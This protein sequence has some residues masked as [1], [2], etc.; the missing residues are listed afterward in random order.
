M[1]VLNATIGIMFPSLWLQVSD[2]ITLPLV[3]GIGALLLAWFLIGNEVMR[4][5]TGHLALWCKHAVDPLGMKQTIKWLSTQSFR[6][7]VQEPKA[8]FTSVAITGLVESWDVPMVWLWNRLHGRRDMVLFEATLRQR[9]AWGL[10]LYRPGTLVAG[11]AQRLAQAEGWQELPLDEFRVAPG[12]G[13]PRELA[14]RLLRALAD[15]RH[16]LVR[17]ALRRQATH[18]ALF[19]NVPDRLRLTPAGFHKLVERLVQA[20]VPFVTSAGTDDGQTGKEL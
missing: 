1:S 8:P 20:T 5:R 14:Q 17:L 19:L 6:L 11:D 15:E 18:L 9:P 7:E 10:E 3:V 13:A 2:R 16:H 12:E 4:R